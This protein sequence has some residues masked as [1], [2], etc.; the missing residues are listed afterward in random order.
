MN[1]GSIER[2]VER[3]KSHDGHDGII[4]ASRGQSLKTTNI[5]CDGA[6]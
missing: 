3:Y 4:V 5:E 6:A 1:E 2:F